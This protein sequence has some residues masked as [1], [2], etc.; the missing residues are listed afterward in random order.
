MHFPQDV[1]QVTGLDRVKRGEKK[2]I[3][4][5]PYSHQSALLHKP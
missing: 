2:T 4:H 3:K 5:A 1:Q